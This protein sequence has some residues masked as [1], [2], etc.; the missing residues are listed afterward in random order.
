MAHH[1]EHTTLITKTITGEKVAAKIR[2][3][4]LR[5]SLTGKT[6]L[7]RLSKKTNPEQIEAEQVDFEEEVARFKSDIAK[8]I[9]QLKQQAYKE[10][11]WITKINKKEAQQNPQAGQR[12]SA[13]SSSWEQPISDTQAVELS[14]FIMT[15]EEEQNFFAEDEYA[16]NSHTIDG[17]ISHQPN[18]A[19]AQPADEETS[20]GWE[21]HWTA[22]NLD[23]RLP[24]N[25]AIG[26]IWCKDSITDTWYYAPQFPHFAAADSGD[27]DWQSWLA[28]VTAMPPPDYYYLENI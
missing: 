27:P 12:S 16:T 2:D 4:R 14:N 18:Q 22:G 5:R 25:P 6:S 13:S 7:P 19:D 11:A 28:E 24:H 1:L 10:P 15:T 17:D 8:D 3:L 26:K 23:T 9:Q 21:Q 20:P